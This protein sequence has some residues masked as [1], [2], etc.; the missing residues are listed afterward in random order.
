[1][2]VDWYDVNNDGHEDLWVGC[3]PIEHPDSNIF[4][5]SPSEQPDALFLWTEDGFVDVAS[6]WGIDRTNNTRGGGF[7]DIN[8]DGCAELARVPRNGPTEIF[9]GTCPEHHAWLDVELDDGNAGIGSTVVVEMNGHRQVRWM[10][11]GGRSIATFFPQVVHF[12]FGATG[13]QTV[14][15]EV[16]WSDG[17]VSEFRDVDTNRRIVFDKQ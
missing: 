16:H 15:V 6:D 5:D 9:I 3:G 7:V 2:G 17:S 10:T 8:Q 14:D 4:T 11:A 1:M 12:G 13:K